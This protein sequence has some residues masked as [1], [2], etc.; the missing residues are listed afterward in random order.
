VRT[1]SGLRDSSVALPDSAEALL[2]YRGAVCA[3]SVPIRPDQ[4]TGVWLLEEVYGRLTSIEGALLMRFNRD[5]TFAAD[6]EGL[7]FAG[8]Q[9]VRGTYRVDGALLRITAKAGYACLRGE[10]NTWRASISADGRLQMAFV[11]GRGCST[12]AGE[13]WIARRV[14]ADTGLPR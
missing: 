6:P 5:G 9:A 8:G 13:V 3:P 12:R 14:L 2:E 7:L 10:R 1:S 4:L 11:R